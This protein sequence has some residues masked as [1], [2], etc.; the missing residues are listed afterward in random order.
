MRYVSGGKWDVDRR[1]GK[2]ELIER[3]LI[4]LMK[5]K[6]GRKIEGSEC[7]RFGRV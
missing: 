1:S 2:D 5:G 3:V 7:L 6:S 4:V